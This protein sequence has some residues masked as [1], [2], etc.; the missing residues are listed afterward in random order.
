L[1]LVLLHLL[2]SL[3]GIFIATIAVVGYGFAPVPWLY[4][5]AYAAI[6]LSLLVQPTMF[7][8]AWYVIGVGTIL[9]AIAIAR[10]WMRGKAR[11]VAAA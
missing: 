7:D 8:G 11:R 3:L 2:L 10:E 5:A 9:A 6:G 4:R 1:L